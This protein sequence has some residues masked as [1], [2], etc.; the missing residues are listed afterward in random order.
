MCV[1]EGVCLWGVNVGMC[2]GCCAI[3][4]KSEREGPLTLRLTFVTW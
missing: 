4:S 3:A 2:R 1:C